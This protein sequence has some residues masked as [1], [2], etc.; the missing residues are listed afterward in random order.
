MTFSVTLRSGRTFEAA[1]GQTILEAARAA[2]V[3]LEYSC[4]TGRCG[5]CRIPSPDGATA[6]TQPETALTDTER[7][8]GIVLT[9]CRAAASDLVIDAEDL[10]RLIG[11]ETRTVP[12]RIA[13][14]ERVSEDILQVQLRTP[15]TAR[16][17]FLPGQYVD[18]IVGPV[19]RSYSLANA[20]R[21]D[22]LLELLIRRYDGGVLSDYWFNRAKPNDLLRL[23]GPFGTFFLRDAG[24][25]HLIFLATGTGIAPVKALIEEIAADPVL[26][27][28][29][30][31]SIYWGNREMASFVWTPPFEE[32]DLHVHPVLSGADDGWQGRRGYVQHALLEDGFDPSDSAIYAC[33]SLQMIA[34]A[35]QACFT[36][37][38][39][40]R[41]F[42]S[43]AFVSSS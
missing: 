31:L 8:A 15:P 18:A 38:L 9:C 1:S 41:R 4:R 39:P 5:V 17:R 20:P 12:C 28:R 27:A 23:E 16:V 34:S 40:E 24:P 35:R 25:R 11:I 3:M 14:M 21:E 36:A 37:G 2:N 42:F 32:L 33:G 30:R 10:G 6:L 7:N 13:G 22:G 19:R 26:A 29:H 43:D